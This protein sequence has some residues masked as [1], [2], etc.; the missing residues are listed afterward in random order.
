[1]RRQEEGLRSHPDLVQVGLQAP[2]PAYPHRHHNP[3]AHTGTTNHLPS[4]IP[5][6]LGI[7][8]SLALAATNTHAHITLA[9]THHSC[10]HAS[11]LYARITLACTHHSCTLA[12]L[13]HTNKKAPSL[14]EQIM[15][16]EVI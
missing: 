10:M 9:C 7:L 1:M 3:P 4:Y 12:S 16:P 11:L 5:T 2:Q 15:G 13:L 6:S 14:R 8:L